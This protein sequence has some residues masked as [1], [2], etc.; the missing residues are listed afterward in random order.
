M[1]YKFLFIFFTLCLIMFTAC[2]I[3][4]STKERIVGTRIEFNNLEKYTVTVYADPQRQQVLAIIPG[5]KKAIAPAT[6]NTAGA[7]FYPTFHLDLFEIPEI[8]IFYEVM[9]PVIASIEANV[10]NKITIDKLASINI[11]HTYIK[12][13]N[14]S[15]ASLTLSENQQLERM[16]L[17]GSSTIINPARTAVYQISPGPIGGYTFMHNAITPISFPPSLEAFESGTIYEMTYNGSTLAIVKQTAI[18]KIVL[19]QNNF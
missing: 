10:L 19:S 17:N 15:T 13:A 12:I 4:L 9:P 7:A 3:G 2:D 8:I 6:P 1:K 11:N 14:N 5:K 16:P 18:S